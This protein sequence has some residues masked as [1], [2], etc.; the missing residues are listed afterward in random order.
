MIG[1]LLEVLGVMFVAL[2]SFVAGGVFMEYQLFA[3]SL[4]EYD[5]K[6]GKLGCEVCNALKNAMG[7]LFSTSFMELYTCCTKEEKIYRP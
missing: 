2:A 1:I 6:T 3:K 5:G 4:A 7:E